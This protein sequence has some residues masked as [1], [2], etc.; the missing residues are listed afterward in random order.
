MIDA[1]RLNH[2][3]RGQRR[4]V[5]QAEV[6]TDPKYAVILPLPNF[7]AEIGIPRTSGIQTEISRAQRVVGNTVTV[8]KAEEFTCAAKL[9]ILSGNIAQ[10]EQ[11]P[12][13]QFVRTAR[14]TPAQFRLC[15]PL[16]SVT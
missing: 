13:R 14:D 9:P 6:D 16:S 11:N 4:E 2:P 8:L 15:E 10:L 1:L 3:A 5:L 7:H 12:G